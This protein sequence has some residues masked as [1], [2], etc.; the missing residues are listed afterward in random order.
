MTLRSRDFESTTGYRGLARTSAKELG[1]EEDN[2]LGHFDLFLPI[3]RDFECACNE[4][5][6]SQPLPYSSARDDGN[7]LPPQNPARTVA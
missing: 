6:V 2:Q 3:L 7:P 4:F 1:T 5:A